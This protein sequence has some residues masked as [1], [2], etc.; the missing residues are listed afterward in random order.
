MWWRVLVVVRGPVLVGRRIRW[1]V[2]VRAGRVRM[3][4]VLMGVRVVRVG[5]PGRVVGVGRVGPRRGRAVR[6]RR[7]MA[8]IRGCPGRGLRELRGRPGWRLPVVVAGMVISVVVAGP[9]SITR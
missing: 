7:F 2:V 9:G 4:P 8:A 5:C 1:S 3:V 6:C